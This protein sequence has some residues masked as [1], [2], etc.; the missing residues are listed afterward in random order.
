MKF[1]KFSSTTHKW[2]GL[3]LGIQVLLWFAS[4]IVMTWFDIELIRSEHNISNIEPPAIT[5]EENIV[6]LKSVIQN[7]GQGEVKNITLK[8]LGED[9]VYQISKQEGLTL[10]V[11]ARTGEKVSPISAEMA[12]KLAKLDFAGEAFPNEAQLLSETGIEYRGVLPVWFVAMNDVDNTNLYINPNTGRVMA[13]RSD[14]WRLYDFFWMLHIMDYENRSDFNHPLVV[15]A[16]IFSFI[17]VITGVFLLFYRFTKKDFKS[18]IG[19]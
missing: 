5:F 6:S 1:S 10:L 13:R 3:V 17:M 15:W 14:I 8:Y 16:T 2:L 19:K 9:L 7:A 11:D 18:L 4:G 12:F